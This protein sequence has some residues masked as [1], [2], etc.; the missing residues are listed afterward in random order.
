MPLADAD[1]VRLGV[2]DSERVAVCVCVT[3]EVG[4]RRPDGVDDGVATDDG[5]AVRAAEPEDDGTAVADTVCTELTVADADADAED[6][7]VGV[8]VTGEDTGAL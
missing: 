3:L 8:G 5:D 7:T 1:V 6:V 4:D 2:A